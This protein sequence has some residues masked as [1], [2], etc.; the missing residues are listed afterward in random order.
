MLF[1]LEDTIMFKTYLQSVFWYDIIQVL[2]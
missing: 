2:I 1:I